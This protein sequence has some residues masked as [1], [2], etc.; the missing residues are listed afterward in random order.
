MKYS[1]GITDNDSAIDVT[2]MTNV[3]NRDGVLHIVNFLDD[4]IIPNTDAPPGTT[5]QGKTPRRSWITRQPTHRLPH[6][7][8]VLLGYA[9]Q[10]SLRTAQDQNRIRH[11]RSFSISARACSKGN[12]S[13]PDALAAS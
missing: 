7:F 6:L 12:T 9:L 5:R 13:F 1:A 2:P 3:D 8:I 10:L 11:G 4:A